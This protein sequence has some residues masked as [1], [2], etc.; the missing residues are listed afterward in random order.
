[1]FSRYQRGSVRQLGKEKVWHGT[2]RED[3]KTPDGQIER[4][5]RQVRLGTREELLT[6]NASR[7]KLADIIGESQP[8]TEINFKELVDRWMAAEGPTL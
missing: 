2:Y 5:Q 4:R 8:T 1:M 3:V 7:A 6:K